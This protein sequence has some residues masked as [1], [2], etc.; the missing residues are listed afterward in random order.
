MVEQ[1]VLRR[2]ESWSRLE[3]LR[4]AR[5]GADQ[6]MR[7]EELG[8]R[9][10]EVCADLA[11][12]RR[13]FPTEPTTLYLNRLAERSNRYLYGARR[14]RIQA[15]GYFYLVTFPRLFRATL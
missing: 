11:I 14:N 12:A 9:Y 2:R 8:W 1:L 15:L 5:G 4:S 13:D 3:S 6:A 10:R 7:A